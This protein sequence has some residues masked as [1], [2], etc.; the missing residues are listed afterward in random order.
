MCAGNPKCRGPVDWCNLSCGPRLVRT[1][2]AHHRPV[3]PSLTERPPGSDPRH[4]ARRAH[5]A[6][7]PRLPRQ[8]R[9]DPAE[10]IGANRRSNG[11]GDPRRSGP[12]ACAQRSEQR[13]DSLVSEPPDPGGGAAQVSGTDRSEHSPPTF[14]AAARRCDRREFQTAESA[15]GWKPRQSVNSDVAQ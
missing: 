2:R 1:P 13:R 6:T 11:Q 7:A 10:K 14:P 9:G 15:A 12:A 4:R 8:A 5:H 3:P